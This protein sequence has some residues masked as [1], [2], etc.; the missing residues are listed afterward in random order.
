MLHNQNLQDQ[1][2]HQSHYQF[3]PNKALTYLQEKETGVGV[4]A[5]RQLAEEEVELVKLKL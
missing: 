1:L 2:V 5:D 3:H 4:V